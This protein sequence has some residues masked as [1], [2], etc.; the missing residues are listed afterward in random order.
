MGEPELELAVV[1]LV[2]SRFPF[3]C[4]LDGRSLL[5]AAFHRREAVEGR[6][7]HGASG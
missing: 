7:G 5:P 4:F 6:T 1:E 3:L 2:G